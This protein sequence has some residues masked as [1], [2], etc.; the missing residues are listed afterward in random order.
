MRI[1]VPMD[2]LDVRDP[3]QGGL[4][5][6]Q[7]TDQGSC[8]HPGADLNGPG[9]G[10][11][12]RYAPERAVLDGLVWS[13]VA[14]GG[15]STGYGTHVWLR[16][17]HDPTSPTGESYNH[18]CHMEDVAAGLAVGQPVASGQPIGRCGKSGLYG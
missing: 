4:T 5:F 17:P 14:W 1:S 10:D 8:Y 9:G 3:T 11:A 2:G 16:Y 12:D 7:L 18:Y 6:C 15:V 13:V